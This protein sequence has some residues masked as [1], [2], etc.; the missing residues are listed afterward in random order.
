M[1][2]LDVERHFSD[3]G[4]GLSAEVDPTGTMLAEKRRPGMA[5]LT[6]WRGISRWCALPGGETGC[7]AS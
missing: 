6:L 5:N 1:D 3:L 2:R 7:P 4:I